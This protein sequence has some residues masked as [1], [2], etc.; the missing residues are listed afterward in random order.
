MTMLRTC[1]LQNVN[2]ISKRLLNALMED[3][4]HVSSCNIRTVFEEI[5][6]Q[7]LNCYGYTN[8]TDTFNDGMPG[9]SNEQAGLLTKSSAEAYICIWISSKT[10]EPLVLKKIFTD[11]FWKKWR[12]S[13]RLRKN[14]SWHG[15]FCDKATQ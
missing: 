6:D 8:D 3:D 12:T 14:C 11:L 1:K 4:V 15:Q 7:T 5:K 13:I 2:S 10:C 9:Y